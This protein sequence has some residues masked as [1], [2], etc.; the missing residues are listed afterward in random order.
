VTWDTL[1]FVFHLPYK[2]SPNG[3][4]LR[5]MERALEDVIYL[6][7]LAIVQLS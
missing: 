4:K 3:K 2:V 1:A 7:N 6:L 5:D